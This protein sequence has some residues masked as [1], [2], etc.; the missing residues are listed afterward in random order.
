MATKTL[1]PAILNERAMS[2]IAPLLD[3]PA[4]APVPTFDLTN[5]DLTFDDVF[6]PNY[7]SAEYVEAMMEANGGVPLEY[8]VEQCT[9]EY[10]YDPTQ[11]ENSG[12]WKP[13]LHLAGTE[14]K[15]VLNKTRAELCIAITGSRRI[16]DWDGLGR[17]HVWAGADKKNRKYQLLFR[18]APD[19]IDGAPASANGRRANDA[20]V[21]DIN[22][23][24]FS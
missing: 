9:I 23:E 3:V 21:T 11:G 1:K 24:L 8:T 5:P 19:A 2:P 4:V 17:I 15:I 18:L 10:V 16:R 14:S 12:E 6:Q 22:E 7:L 13:V 20:V